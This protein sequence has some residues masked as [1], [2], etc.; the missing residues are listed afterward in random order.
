MDDK[1]TIGERCKEF[2]EQNKAK[3]LIGATAVLALAGIAE[4]D[5]RIRADVAAEE[6]TREDNVDQ[7]NESST[8]HREHGW[9]LPNDD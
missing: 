3:I 4:V 2:W 9:Y 5:S 1:K 7:T 6:Q 8:V